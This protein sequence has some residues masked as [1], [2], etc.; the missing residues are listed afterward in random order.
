MNT[1]DTAVKNLLLAWP[2]L[3]RNRFEAITMIFTSSCYEW[4]D[5]DLKLTCGGCVPETPPTIEIFLQHFRDELTEATENKKNESYMPLMDL[6]NTRILE[7]QADLNRAQ[8]MADNIDLVCSRFWYGLG[9]HE[10]TFI[11]GWLTSAVRNGGIDYWP[12]FN[13]PDNVKR[14]WQEAVRNWLRQSLPH[15]RPHWGRYYEKPHDQKNGWFPSYDAED[16]RHKFFVL[17]HDLQEK[18]TWFN[19][20]EKIEEERIT[21]EVVN[22]ILAEE[23]DDG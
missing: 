2:T 23:R 15:I 5:G 14:E 20:V 17:M 8:L 9:C 4:V 1:V 7:A 19:K 10:S 13:R 6:H 22:K 12:I 3:Y 16:P 18:W 11:R 21:R